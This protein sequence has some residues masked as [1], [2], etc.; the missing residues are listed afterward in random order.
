MRKTI[1]SPIHGTRWTLGNAEEDSHTSGVFRASVGKEV[2]KLRL[3]DAS[4]RTKRSCH[5]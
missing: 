5:V 1:T 2:R 4:L 3:E